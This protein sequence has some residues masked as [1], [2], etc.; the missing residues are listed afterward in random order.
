MPKASGI[1]YYYNASLFGAPSPFSNNPAV[2]RE[3]MIQRNIERNIAELAVNRFK[4]EGLPDSIDPRFLEITL[5]LNGLAIFYWDD[6]FDKLL[7]VKASSSGYVN[8]MDWP[9]SYTVIG[10]GSKIN[11]IAGETTFMPK[12]LS[13]YNPFK[14]YKDGEA[15]RKAIPMW[16]NYFRQPEIDTINLYAGR[17]ATTDMTLEINTRNARQNKVV[18]STSNT[19]LSM[20]NLVRQID[21]GV[22]VIQPKDAGMLENISAI[23]LGIDYHLFDSLSILRTRWWNECMGLLGIDNANQDKKERLVADEVSANNGQTDSMRFAALNA[24][25]QAAEYINTVFGDKI[26]GEVTVEFN[27]EVEAM[28]RQAAA[29]AGVNTSQDDM[30]EPKDGS[31]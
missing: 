24:R 30:P 3:H 14:E 28:E 1:D 23:D 15:Q 16:P 29:M 17:L 7:A 20:V 26:D 25:K 6:N 10:P 12:T 13:G 11:D 9:T 22:N 19:Q 5:L 4:W 27:T 21:E 18:V 2:T 8:F 31:E